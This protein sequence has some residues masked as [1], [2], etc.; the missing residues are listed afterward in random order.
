MEKIDTCPEC[1]E[2]VDQCEICGE[3]IHMEDTQVIGGDGVI[4][5][6]CH[7]KKTGGCVFKGGK[8]DVNG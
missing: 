4:C 7:K 5:F 3:L 2:Y 6:S 1:Q 8:D